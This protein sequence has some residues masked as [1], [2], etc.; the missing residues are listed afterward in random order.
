MKGHFKLDLFQAV[1]KARKILGLEEDA[2]REEIKKVYRE[3]I[4]KYHPDKVG[5]IRKYLEK[6]KQI[7]WAYSVIASYCDDYRFSF[8][9]EDVEKMDPDLRLKRQFS[10]DWLMK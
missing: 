10:D 4:K 6:S 2:T 3:V 9:R 7:N 8:R 5:D 1:D